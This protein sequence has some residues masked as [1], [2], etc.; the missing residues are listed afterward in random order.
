V[1]AISHLPHEP[2]QGKVLRSPRRLP[3]GLRK[4][5]LGQPGLETVIP[6]EISNDNFAH[7]IQK[8]AADPLVHTVLEIGASSGSGS[9]KHLISGLTGKETKD[10]Y[11]L[12]LSRPRFKKLTKRYRKLPWVHCYNLPSVPL[13]MMPRPSDIAEFFNAHPESPIHRHDLSVVQSW[14]AADI[15]Y[16][17]EIGPSVNGIQVALRD[18]AVS[19]F[20]MVLIDGSEFAG[21]SEM[22]E[23]YGA[24]YIL[25]DDTMTFKNWA[26]FVK[27]STDPRYELIEEDSQCRNGF[28]AFRHR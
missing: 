16:L 22:R 10:L 11:C 27:L 2:E 3:S 5:F 1:P 9:T 25:L 20:D 4:L 19:T 26:N 24:T 21:M 17:M 14:L 18:A 7:L 13:Q 8:L 23:V 15:D 6:P 12:E 28:A